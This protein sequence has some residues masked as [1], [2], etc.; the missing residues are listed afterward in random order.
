MPTTTFIAYDF[1]IGGTLPQNLEGAV[2]KS[3]T[4]YPIRWPGDP[5]GQSQGAIWNTIVRP[6]IAA[7]DR[8]LAFVDLPNANVGFEVGYG[9]GLG[10]A[11][12]LARVRDALPAWVQAPPLHGFL[13]PRLMTPQSIRTQVTTPADQWNQL[14]DTPT[15][16]PGVLLLCPTVTGASFLDELPEEWGWKTPPQSGWDLHTLPELL[17]G[18]GLVVWVLTPH[19]QGDDGRD[20]PENAQ[21]AV[22][23]GYV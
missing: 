11:V 5:T 21:L 20:G 6:G 14:T 15:R 9:L 1:E 13:C 23:A 19:N 2:R 22:V 3:S 4:E 17:E 16:G 7:A 12:G 8:L 18:V 10:K